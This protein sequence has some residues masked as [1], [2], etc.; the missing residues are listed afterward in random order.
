MAGNSSSK[1][2]DKDIR[3]L[4][5]DDTRAMRMMLRNHLNELGYKHVEETENGEQAVSLLMSQQEAKP[6]RLVISDWKMP[7]TT[8]IQLLNFIRKSL[9]GIQ[10]KVIFV[11]AES[12]RM[13]ILTALQAGAN[14]YLVKPFD[15]KDFVKALE[16]AFKI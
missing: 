13:Q 3:I 15:P 2:P 5:V 9:P 7:I 8:G 12:E 1:L 6:F 14:A 11:S 4:V 16:S 10:P